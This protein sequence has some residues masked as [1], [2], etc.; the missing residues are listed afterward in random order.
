MAGFL[1]EALQRRTANETQRSLRTT[2]RL[3]IGLVIYFVAV[4]IACVPYYLLIEQ[5]KRQL[6]KYQDRFAGE[7]QNY[8]AIVP[9]TA[10]PEPRGKPYL[11]GKA[12]VLEKT[13]SGGEVSAVHVAQ[14]PEI[15][16]EA[17]EEVGT[18]V[19][20]EWKDLRKGPYPGTSQV[21]YFVQGDTQVFDLAA[22][23]LVAHQV[24]QGGD[25]PDYAPRDGGH[26]RGPKPIAAIA[27]YL[28]K[29]ERKPASVAAPATGESETPSDKDQGNPKPEP[30]AK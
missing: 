1:L 21:G 5:P 2:D 8:L 24:F 3:A 12:V 19:L 7:I 13:A 22:K 11:A 20:V 29:L 28:A 4:I 17:P 18:V 9:D 27:E 6:S 15:R 25:P 10:V 16:A 26:G 23:V 14:N 30:N